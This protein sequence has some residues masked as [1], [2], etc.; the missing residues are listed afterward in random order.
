MDNILPLPGASP[1][2]DTSLATASSGAGGKD[3]GEDVSD[4]GA[5]SDN[6]GG[7][8]AKPTVED[9]EGIEGESGTELWSWRW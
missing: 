1:Y 5:R 8:G 3:G 2:E 6:S 9:G 4:E 7:A